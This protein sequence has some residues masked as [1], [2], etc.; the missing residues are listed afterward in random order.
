MRA[1]P[2]RTA[3]LCA[4][5]TLCHELT[6][7]FGEL[8][9]RWPHRRLPT[10]ASGT[11]IVKASGWSHFSVSLKPRLWFPRSCSHNP[12]L[13]SRNLLRK[14]GPWPV[15]CPQLSARLSSHFPSKFSFLSNLS[16]SL[17]SIALTEVRPPSA[18]YEAFLPASL[19]QQPWRIDAGFLPSSPRAASPC[20]VLPPIPGLALLACFVCWTLSSLLPPSLDWLLVLHL[21]VCLDPCLSNKLRW[22]LKRGFK[23]KIDQIIASNTSN[24]CQDSH[25]SNAKTFPNAETVCRP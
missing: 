20:S 1:H 16:T 23:C 14:C 9:P 5:V 4:Q 7:G 18:A 19:S 10:V 24:E 3:W 13:W 11:F 25:N 2:R 22:V 15:F 8:L 17:L 21:P 12:S 6:V